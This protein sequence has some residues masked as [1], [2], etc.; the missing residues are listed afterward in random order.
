[1]DGPVRMFAR[2]PDGST[3]TKEAPTR[4][5]GVATVTE[6]IRLGRCDLA[7]VIDQDG[8]ILYC[9]GQ[10]RTWSIEDQRS[11][12]LGDSVQSDTDG[13]RVRADHR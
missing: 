12:P 7:C 10:G 3:R 8:E 1:M 13:F 2:L 9:V 4:Q 6:L 11:R 5:E